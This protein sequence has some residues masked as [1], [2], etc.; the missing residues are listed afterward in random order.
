MSAVRPTGKLADVRTASCNHGHF[1][2]SAAASS[3]WAREHRDGYV[4][5]VEEAFRLDRE[6]ITRL[7][8]AAVSL[9]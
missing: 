6:V 5:P 8:W 3:E 1:F 9:P 2:S 7:G 4:H